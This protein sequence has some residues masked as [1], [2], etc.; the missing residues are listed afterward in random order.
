MTR[1]ILTV[2]VA[3]LTGISLL[4]AQPAT[5]AD[6]YTFFGGGYGHGIGMSQW[7]AYGLVGKGW[8]ANRIM[9]H[10]FQG[11][12]V[13][14]LAPPAKLFR[15]GLVQHGSELNL[16]ATAGRMRLELTDGTFVSAVGAGGSR[17]IRITKGQRYRVIRPDGSVVGNKAW[18]GPNLHLR[19]RRKSGGVIKVAEWDGGRSI[20]RGYLEFDIVGAQA[21]HVVAV[22]TPESYLYGIAEVWAGWPAKAL[23]VQAM[24]SRTYAYHKV[25][26]NPKQRQ[27]GCSCGLYSS[28]R[29]QY[30][31]GR[32][33]ET[34]QYGDRWVSAVRATRRRVVTY[35][36][37]PILA[38]Y[39]SSSGGFTEHNENI[40]G[41]SAEPYL[42]GRCDP[43]D[44][45]RDNVHRTWKVTLS[46]SDAAAKLRSAFG[47]NISRVTQIDV[48]RRGVSGRVL[49]ATIRG[50]NSSGDRVAFTKSGWDLRN[51]FGLEDMRYWVNRNYLVT[52]RIRR[53]YDALMCRPKLPR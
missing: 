8:G 9:K 26:A 24:A 19:A 22:V 6:S 47:W 53:A 32:D 37:R 13:R 10:Y 15:I 33:K 43:G 40:W 29:D 17:R 11:T 3:A 39:S 16:T 50:R 28:T 45:V 20:G 30:F 42:R 38:M 31:V 44:F 1:R 51:A 7:G 23:Q 49:E 36:G 46:A 21:A 41:G 27:D 35:S 14:E 12:R 18:G 52:A 48:R 34:G 2:A 5:A 4:P 25:R